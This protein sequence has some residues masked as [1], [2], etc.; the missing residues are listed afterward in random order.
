[1]AAWRL[2]HSRSAEIVNAQMVDR[3]QS[4]PQWRQQGR[5]QQQPPASMAPAAMTTKKMERNCMV[6]LLGK[7]CRRALHA[8]AVPNRRT[9]C[10]CR[11]NCRPRH[12]M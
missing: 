3:P 8:R 7:V 9:S 12:E 4:I 5:Q 11:H 10:S 1:M 6:A 2:A